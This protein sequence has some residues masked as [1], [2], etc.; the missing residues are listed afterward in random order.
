M[1]LSLAVAVAA[2]VVA[3]ALLA[4]AFYFPRYQRRDLF[5][6]YVALNAGVFAVTAVLTTTHAGLG[7]GL[8]LFGILSIIRLRSSA[9]S[10]EEV[11]YYFVALALGLVCGLHP[12]P[13]WLAPA[14]AGALVGTMFVADHPRAASGERRQRVTLD[15]AYPDAG[16]ARAAVEQLLGAGV[17]VV[18]VLELDLVMDLTVVDVRLSAGSASRAAPRQPEALH[19]VERLAS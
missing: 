18:D 17:R 16:A 19:R 15:R 7:L 14:V 13:L 12:E 4:R 9:I 6:A 5:L 2:D 3:I 8:G 11:A 1:V 10:Q